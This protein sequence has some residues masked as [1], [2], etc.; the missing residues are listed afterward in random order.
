MKLDCRN[1][2]VVVRQWERSPA[3]TSRTGGVQEVTGV[4][5]QQQLTRLLCDM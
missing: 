5:Q 3:A 2:A 4:T 1:A